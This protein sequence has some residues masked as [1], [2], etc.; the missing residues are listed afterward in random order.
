MSSKKALDVQKG[1]WGVSRE[2]PGS[3]LSSQRGHPSVQEDPEDIPGDPWVAPGDDKESSKV[4][5]GRPGDTLG[6]QEE[7]H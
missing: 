4:V 5:L 1:S 6:A 3:P 7:F 2:A